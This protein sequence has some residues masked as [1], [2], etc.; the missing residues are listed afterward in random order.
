MS[1]ITTRLDALWNAFHGRPKKEPE[2]PMTEWHNSVDEEIVIRQP[3]SV[4]SEFPSHG[5]LDST[6]A[7]QGSVGGNLLDVNQQAFDSCTDVPRRAPLESRKETPRRRIWRLDSETEIELDRVPSNTNRLELDVRSDMD[8]GNPDSYIASVDDVE[9]PFLRQ[10][11]ASQ[12]A[13]SN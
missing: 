13:G 6:V 11:S 8:P 10:N 4:K 2:E 3:L 12:T 5:E 7:I 1:A 9:L